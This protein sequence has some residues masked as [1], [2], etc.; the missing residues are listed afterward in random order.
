MGPTPALIA[1]STRPEP[2]PIPIPALTPTPTPALTSIPTVAITP[3]NTPS[4]TPELS[5]SRRAIDYSERLPIGWKNSLQPQDLQWIGQQLWDAP[6]KMKE[7][8]KLWWNPPDPPGP[9]IKGI[10]VPGA[11]FHRR[12]FLWMPRKMWRFDFKCPRCAKQSPPV[13]HS[14]TSKGVYTTVQNVV[15]MNENY[16][17][18]AEY[19]ECRNCTKTFRAYDPRLLES[20][21]FRIR[22]LFPIVK[23]Y[24]HAMDHTVVS[25][26]RARTVGNSTT[27]ICKRIK[28]KHGAEWMRRSTAY[29]TDCKQHR[30][31]RRNLG[32]SPVKYEPEIAY[33]SP[34]T[35]QWFLAVYTRDVFARLPILKASLT[36]IFGQIL[37]I[38]STKQVRV[39]YHKSIL[40]VILYK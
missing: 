16:Y 8:L 9:I 3:S 25:E 27:A 35:E 15:A 12:L 11:Y 22:S 30:D 14:L 24:K 37:K 1:A 36:S 28:E 17:L 29:L 34:P 19:Y 6:H 40:N 13:I 4:L 10:P 5:L 23:T 7:K 32:L 18:A 39:Y 33:Q 38:D 26:M 20:L 21:P 2:P 31:G